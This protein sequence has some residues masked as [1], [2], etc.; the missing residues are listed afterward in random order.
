M[1]SFDDIFNEDE[2]RAFDERIRKTIKYPTYTEEP[3]M[4]GLSG[5]LI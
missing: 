2:I 4:D 5:S 3:K 1:L